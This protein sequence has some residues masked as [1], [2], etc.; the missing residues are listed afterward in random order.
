V[1]ADAVRGMGTGILGAVGVIH[2]R[3]IATLPSLTKA[4]LLPIWAENFP[5]DPP[6][7]LRKELIVPIL[8]YRIQ[9]REF[10]G[11]PLTS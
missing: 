5:T 11:L 9:E 7:K 3:L 8:A 10:G 1:L 4:Q 2:R 6:P